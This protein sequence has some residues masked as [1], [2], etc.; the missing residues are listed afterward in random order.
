MIL[1]SVVP[2]ETVFAN[3]DQVEKQEL[4]EVTIGHMTMLVEPT[5]PFEG[6][7]VRMISPLP[8]DYLNPRCA[9]G[10]TIAFHPNGFT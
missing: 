7:I 1:H 10:Q 8:Q 5:G 9:P 6:K 4:K 3:M 2:M